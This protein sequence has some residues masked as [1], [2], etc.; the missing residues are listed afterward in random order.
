MISEKRLLAL[1]AAYAFVGQ[2]GIAVLFPFF[3]QNFS[4]AQI[5]SQATLGFLVPILI[6]PFVRS[7]RIRTAIIAG[8]IAAGARFFYTA[9]VDQPHELYF[10]ALIAGLS[11]VLFWIPF[12]ILYFNKH[13]I[14]NHGK[15]SAWYFAI[16]SS[17]AILISPSAGVI[18]DHFGFEKLFILSSVLMII[19]LVLAVR[20]PVQTV[21]VTL[22]ESL[23]HLRG[24]ITLFIFDG[25]FWSIAPGL[26]ALSLLN[27]TSTATQ[28]GVV[29]SFVAIGAMCVSILAAHMSDRKRNRAAVIYPVSILSAAVMVLLGFQK[30]LIPFTLLFL[31]LSS[32]KT[33]AQPVNNALPMDLRHDHAKL[34]MGRQFLISVGRVFG[35]GLTWMSVLTFGLF[36]MYLIY[37]LG[38]LLYTLVVSRVLRRPLLTVEP[39]PLDG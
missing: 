18:A 27:F 34:Y 20:L 37:A 22:K 1:Q 36:P 9:F 17:A 3:R 11:S 19:P 28:F 14:G 31:V 8:V 32:L 12:E 7:F 2:L 29:N 24:V 25:V 21:N 33:I 5:S 4:F 35:F 30:S 15:K 10:Y 6:I 38:Y 13:D 26:I 16:F 23:K 39:L